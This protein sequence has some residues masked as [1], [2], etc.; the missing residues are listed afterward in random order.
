MSRVSSL[1]RTIV[2]RNVFAVETTTLYVGRLLAAAW[3]PN[4]AHWHLVD[5]CNACQDH[6]YVLNIF[7]ACDDFVTMLHRATRSTG[8]VLFMSVLLI[9]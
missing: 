8:N 4:D 5:T 2:D 9:S 6:G 1:E 3:I 7:S